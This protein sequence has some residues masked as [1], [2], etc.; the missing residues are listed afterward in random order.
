MAQLLLPL[1]DL[2]IAAQEPEAPRNGPS[3][4]PPAP[5]AA[6]VALAFVKSKSL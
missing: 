4:P 2:M 6:A 5:A 3:P 1:R